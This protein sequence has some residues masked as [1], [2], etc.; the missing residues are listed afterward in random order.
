MA[1]NISA[2]FVCTITSDLQMCLQHIWAKDECLR[3]RGVSMVLCGSA[4]LLSQPTCSTS[5][6][7]LLL[8]FAAGCVGVISSMHDTQGPPSLC[9]VP[10]VFMPGKECLLMCGVVCQ[11][12]GVHV[13]VLFIGCSVAA[14]LVCWWSCLCHCF[15]RSWDARPL[16]LSP[17]YTWTPQATH[18]K[19]YVRHSVT[20][21]FHSFVTK[22]ACALNHSRSFSKIRPGCPIYSLMVYQQQLRFLCMAMYMYAG[23][24]ARCDT[25]V[26]YCSCQSL[27]IVRAAK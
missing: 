12:P 8:A 20:S 9:I 25:I 4:R 26:A 2:M 23:L 6:P 16:S 10:S 3:R 13:S 18:I 14:W 11:M 7:V 17:C 21:P 24:R 5:P 19:T 1:G 22:D 15:C 27:A